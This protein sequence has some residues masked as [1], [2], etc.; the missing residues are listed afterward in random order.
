MRFFRIM[1]TV[2]S[3]LVIGYSYASIDQTKFSCLREVIGEK[4]YFHEETIHSSSEG[5]Y[6][7]IDNANFVQVPQIFFDGQG[8]FLNIDYF[9]TLQEHSFSSDSLSS[10]YWTCAKCGYDKNFFTNRCVSC[11]KH[12]NEN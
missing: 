8:Y 6:I 1:T 4:I 12:V 11:G 7:E 2:I 9:E 5:V 10:I 3:F